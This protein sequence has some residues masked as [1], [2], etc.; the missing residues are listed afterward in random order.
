MPDVE[1]TGKP[2]AWTRLYLGVLCYLVVII[3]LLRIF[4]RAFFI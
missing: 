1:Q 4:S 2:V 3:V